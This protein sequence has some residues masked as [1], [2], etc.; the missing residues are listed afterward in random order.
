MKEIKQ[1]SGIM[2]LTANALGEFNY[3]EDFGFY[4]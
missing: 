4:A 2:R 1:V 3:Q